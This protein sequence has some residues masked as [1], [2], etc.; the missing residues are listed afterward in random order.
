MKNRD[1]HSE[2]K[3]VC[4]RKFLLFSVLKPFVYDPLVEWSKPARGQR[5]NPTDTGEIT[6]EQVLVILTLFPINQDLGR[7][8]SHLL[9]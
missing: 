2:Q 4:S 1:F 6:N 9:M 7:L 3:S 5:M 8:L